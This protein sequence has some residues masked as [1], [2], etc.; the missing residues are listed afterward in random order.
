MITKILDAFGQLGFKLEEVEGVGYSFEYEGADFLYMV[1]VQNLEFLTIAVP[2][3]Y[4]CDEAEK[5]ALYVLEDKFN[6]ALRYVKIYTIGGAL[7]LFYERELLEEDN[8]AQVISH[9]ICHLEF[10]L[11][12]IRRTLEGADTETGNTVSA[13]EEPEAKDETDTDE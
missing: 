12:Y 4:E 10:A 2:G 11:S 13:I 3:F 8:P 9:M 7:W 5:S 1:N 6:A